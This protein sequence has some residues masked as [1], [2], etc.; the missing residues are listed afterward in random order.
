M[1]GKCGNLSTPWARRQGIP[2]SSVWVEIVKDHVRM[3]EPRRNASLGPHLFI[4]MG[5]EA[6]DNAERS[7]PTEKNDI[8]DS[9]KDRCV[10]FIFDD[11]AVQH[12][13]S[14]VSKR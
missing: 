2:P 14:W 7:L 12:H 8:I 1:G 5:G 6:L 4:L 13:S 3:A 10:V 9:R 11:R